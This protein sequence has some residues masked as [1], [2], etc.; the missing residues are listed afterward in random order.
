MN[1]LKYPWLRDLG[2]KA[3][4]SAMQQAN[5]MLKRTGVATFPQ[6]ISKDVLEQLKKETIAK[7][8]SAFVTDDVHNAY[9]LHEKD[10]AYP[11]EHVRNRMMRTRVAS[12]AY[13]NLVPNGELSRF[14]EDENLAKFIGIV[15]GQKTCYQSSDPLGACSVNVF[16]PGWYHAWHFD[17]AEYTT[18]LMIQKP[19]KGGIFEFTPVLR[20]SQDDL[21][22]DR[23][24]ETIQQ[25]EGKNNTNATINALEFEEGTLAIFAGRYSLHRV[26]PVYGDLDRLVAVLTFASEP[27]YINSPEVQK[28]FWGR[29]MKA[30][31]NA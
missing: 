15:Q 26:S 25:S 31:I 18:T 28:M 2:S 4:R 8:P 22:F 6:F 16:S 30:K 3:A 12:I 1:F 11:D 5:V 29:S 23:V 27:G 10:L 13:D 9:Q 7:S 19:E 21:V 20:N 24:E 17:E 14:Y